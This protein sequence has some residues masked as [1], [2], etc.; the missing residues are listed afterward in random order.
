MKWHR[1][2]YGGAMRVSIDKA[3]RVVIPKR[4]RDEL[5][6]LPGQDLELNTRSDGIHISVPPLRVRII[7]E[8]RDSR[9]VADDQ[10]PHLSDET[11]RATLEAVRDRR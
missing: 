4:V 6:L 1:L 9:L 10:V 8:G 2:W 11:I 3:G 7:G 5:G